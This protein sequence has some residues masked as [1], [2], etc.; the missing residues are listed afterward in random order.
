MKQERDRRVLYFSVSF[1]HLFC[2]PAYH[3]KEGRISAKQRGDVTAMKELVGYSIFF[4]GIGILLCE[5]I[6]NDVIAFILILVCFLL[7]YI[8]FCKC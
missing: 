8:L 6:G 7:F 1:F 4:I 2:F 5:I 3:E